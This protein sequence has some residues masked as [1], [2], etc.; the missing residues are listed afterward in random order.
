LAKNWQLFEKS[1]SEKEKKTK[2]TLFVL[3]LVM[4]VNALSYGLIIPLLYP[5]AEKFGMSSFMV[6]FMFSIYSVFQFFSTPIIGRLSDRYGRKPLLVTSL[7]GTAVGLVLFAVATNP[8]M[9]FIA[10]IIDGITGGNNSVAQA[11]IADQVE[12][13]E[14]TKYF[15]IIGAVF[16]MGFL[17][18]P[19]LGGF[20]S[21]VSLTFP[22]V[23]GAILAAISAIMAMILLPETNTKRHEKKVQQE[24][25]FQFKK[26]AHALKIPTI[27]H[28]L[29]VVLLSSI[30]HNMFIMGFQSF[31]V[32]ALKLG[33]DQ[34]GIMYS[35]IGLLMVLMQAVGIKMLLKIFKSKKT[36]LL[37]SAFLSS[38]VMFAFNIPQSTVLFIVI[39]GV[40]MITFAP[41]MIM[42]SSMISEYTHEEDQ[43]GILGINQA[44]MALGQIIGPLLAG[45]ANYFHHSASFSIAGLLFFGIWIVIRQIDEHTA[46]ADL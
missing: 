13:K 8:L 29:M 21:K 38:F 27:G 12:V 34:I 26:I 42:T 32:D 36:I 35:L 30:A 44:Y 40:Y 22:F 41:Q 14:R 9:L 19:A 39:S 37:I 2:K 1:M 43:G 33:A 25:L 11:V 15:G 18:G 20:L 5:Y 7:F 4:L 31:S 6:G 10:R 23:V 46:K 16:G 24:G 28:I 17:L 45:A 3:S